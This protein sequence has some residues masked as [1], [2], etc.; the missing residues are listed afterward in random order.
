MIPVVT[1]I[2]NYIKREQLIKEKKI[3]LQKKIARNQRDSFQR[4]AQLLQKITSPKKLE[5][6]NH[7]SSQTRYIAK[8]Q[9]VDYSERVVDFASAWLYSK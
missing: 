9:S 5:T 6:K 7:P 2:V 4:H 3:T 8:Q 1:L